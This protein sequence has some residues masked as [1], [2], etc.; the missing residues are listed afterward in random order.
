MKNVDFVIFYEGFNREYQNIYLLKKELEHRGHTVRFSH[1]SMKDYYDTMRHYAPQIV[2]CPWLRYSENVFRY[3]SFRKPIKHLVNL[4]W[5]QIFSKIG[6]REGADATVGE[7]IKYPHLCWGQNSKKRL[8]DAGVS[9]ENLPVCGGI[10]LD[11]CRPA[12]CESLF[13]KD[14][15]AR[16]FGFDPDKRLSL[17]IS[18][19]DFASYTPEDQATFLKRYGN[20]FAPMFA[21]SA[22][23][24]AETLKWLGAA[25][26][27]NPDT[28]FVY[29]PHPAEKITE[30]LMRME[31][32]FSNFRV[33]SKYNIKQ[34]IYAADCIQMWFSTSIAEI[35]FMGKTCH[36][37]RPFPLSE[38]QEVEILE[39][40]TFV[41][42][43]ED[44][45][46]RMRAGTEGQDFPVPE[47]RMRHYYTIE[48][49]CA[50]ERIADYLED[51]LRNGEPCPQPQFTDEEKKD[52]RKKKRKW[53][54]AA[55][56]YRLCERTGIRFS[57][58]LLFGR[59]SFRGIERQIQ[60]FSGY[61]YAGVERSVDR[62]YERLHAKESEKSSTNG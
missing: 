25:C 52:F 4:Q 16:E 13:S 46:R 9:E 11:F 7:A 12:F 56:F 47:E 39:G 58:F 49:A 44:F 41:T 21:C 38:D 27:Q 50:Y 34:W 14:D 6:I 2:V 33:L 62:I 30:D 36:I 28:V 26:E 3:T 1:F 32:D 55:Y 61:D 5:E 45:L 20:G 18:S 40:G 53:M 57:Q 48:D 37:L 51:L 23:S 54:R 35:Y 19:F 42:D 17:Y 24:K 59:E 22:K 8:M 10:H 31:K 43:K 29:R 15:L 60:L